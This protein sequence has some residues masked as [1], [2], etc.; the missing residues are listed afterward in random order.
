MFWRNLFF[1]RHEIV[2]YFN[3]GKHAHGDRKW[4]VE[5]PLP[6]LDARDNIH[7]RTKGRKT[8]NPCDFFLQGNS[9]MFTTPR[10]LPHHN[11]PTFCTLQLWIKAT[12]VYYTDPSRSLP[13]L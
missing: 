13:P 2:E 11:V 1:R 9:R 8:Y 4:R 7:G 12:T 6:R 3:F 10:E 5:K